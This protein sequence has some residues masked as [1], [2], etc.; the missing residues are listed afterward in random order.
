MIRIGTAGWSIPRDVAE[1][2]AAGQSA[3][4]RYAAVF[5]SVEIN[6]SFYRPHRSATYARWAA[7]VPE[8]FRFA[9]KLPKTITHDAALVG[10][11][12][13]IDRFLEES[14]SLGSKRGPILIQTP[15]K[16]AFEARAAVA[17]AD[18]LMKTGAPLVAWEPRHASWF[19][20]DADA[21][22]AGHGI[23]RVAADPARHPNAGA[24]GGWPGL[25]YYRLHGSPRMYYSGYDETALS[26]L[27]DAL[28]ASQAET[29]IM[30]DNTASGEAARNAMTLARLV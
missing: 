30:F 21:L 6:S 9:V 28:K 5:D 22:L 11:E 17:I 27:A 15:P 3:L 13:L 4:A 26:N 24:P 23:A 14:S 25:A 18:R 2:F 16:L 10:A 1:R 8:H 7:S 29:W 12:A 20:P 19:E